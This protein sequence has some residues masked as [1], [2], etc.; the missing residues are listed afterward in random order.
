MFYVYK[1]CYVKRYQFDHCRHDFE[2]TYRSH[3]DPSTLLHFRGLI[4]DPALTLG[5]PL[6]QRVPVRQDTPFLP[7]DQPETTKTL[8]GDDLERVHRA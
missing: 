8:C 4:D 2:E 7:P 6:L 5:S 3:L 1:I